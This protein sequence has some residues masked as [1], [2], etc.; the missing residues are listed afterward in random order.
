MDVA[1]PRSMKNSSENPLLGGAEGAAFGV[2]PSGSGQPNPYIPERCEEIENL[3]APSRS[4]YS[5]CLLI[6]TARVSKRLNCAEDCNG[7]V[8][9]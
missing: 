4:R 7:R 6:S 1:I 8:E 5:N 2:G 3:A 9:S